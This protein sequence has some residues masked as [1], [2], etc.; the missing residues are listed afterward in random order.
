M[1]NNRLKT[2]ISVIIQGMIRAAFYHIMGVEQMGPLRH[3]LQHSYWVKPAGI[4][5]TTEEY[6]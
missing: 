4:D 1:T 2:Y 3:A 5:G 6:L